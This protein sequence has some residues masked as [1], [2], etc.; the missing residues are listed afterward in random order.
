MERREFLLA[1][2]GALVCAG[3]TPA[4]ALAAGAMPGGLNRASFAPL[5][6]QTLIVYDSARGVA[7]TLAA[8]K[9]G[10]SFPGL[11]QF[12]LLLSGAVASALPSGSYE[13]YH[14][15]IGNL[16]LYLE[17][18]GTQ[19]QDAQYRVQFSLLG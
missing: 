17:A 1:S 6:G 16:P 11:D 10:K 15:S 3:M 13:V 4:L 5:V 18:C 12:T 14:A 19:G 2:G 8:L 7:L 9:D